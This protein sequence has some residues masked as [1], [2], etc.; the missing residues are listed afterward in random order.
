MTI[1]IHILSYTKI[2]LY[3]QKAIGTLL[4]VLL[5]VKYAVKVENNKESEEVSN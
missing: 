1:N 2:K 3:E 5:G 4:G